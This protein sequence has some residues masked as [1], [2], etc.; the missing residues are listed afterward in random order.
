MSDWT[1]IS[2]FQTEA[3]R[4][5]FASFAFGAEWQPNVDHRGGFQNMTISGGGPVDFNAALSDQG[6]LSFINV[7]F[8]DAWTYTARTVNNQITLGSCLLSGFT[9]NGFTYFN[10][11][12]C[13]GVNG[14]NVVLNATA[15]LTATTYFRATELD[16]TLTL[17][18]VGAN[19]CDMIWLAS[20]VAGMLTLNGALVHVSG[21]STPINFRNGVTLAGGAADP[22]FV[23][24]GAKAGNA[25]LASV[26]TQ[27][28]AWG[29]WV[30]TTT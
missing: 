21:D 1:F 14:T 17:N 22:R 18:S 20:A 13:S 15:G 4:V 29:R 5:T 12:N 8:A 10:V 6:K 7:W 9:Q 27:L 24:A 28:Q 16:G 23:L 26:C 19:F 11:M 30:D 3:T 25:A 2:G